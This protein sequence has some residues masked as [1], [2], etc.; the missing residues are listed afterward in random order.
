MI[1]AN[2]EQGK[3]I[4]DGNGIDLLVE[5]TQICRIMYENH[6][7]TDEGLEKLVKTTKMTKEELERNSLEA[8]DKILNTGF[9]KDLF[10]EFCKNADKYSDSDA[11]KKAFGD[12]LDEE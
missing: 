11:F 5:L 7:L 3:Y 12:I 8:F 6:I 10:E 4:I 1:K 9:L 2:R